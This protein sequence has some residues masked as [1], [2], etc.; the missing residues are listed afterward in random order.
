MN[1][2]PFLMR[3]YVL[4]ALVATLLLSACNKPLEAPEAVIEKAKQAVIDV[5]SGQ[6]EVV[7]TVDG[8]NGR[9]D[10]DFDGNMSLT[11]DKREEDNSKFDLHLDVSGKMQTGEQNLDGDLDVNFITMDKE[12]YVMLNE[13]SSSDPSVASIEPFINLYS[14]KW[15][16]IAEDFIP[17][18]IRE[19]QGQDEAF[20]LKKKQLEDLFA[21]TTLFDVVK[22]Y[23]VEKL[24]GHSVHHYGLAVNMNG[25]KDY[26][27]KAAIIDG[28][29]LT[30][31]E[32][33][34][35]VTVLSY[36]REAEVYID[37]DTYHIIKSVFRFSGEA[38]SSDA[39]LEVEIV[40]DGSDYNKSVSIEV[41][42]D[43][44]DFNPLNLIMGL[45]GVPALPEEDS[46][47]LEEAVSEAMEEHGSVMMEEVT[48]E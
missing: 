27:S 4:L 19:L 22:E 38:I 12:Y 20:M 15:L 26:M 16:R 13:L 21:E 48:E 37:V 31:Q 33:E 28:R 34:E 17:E 7:A 11:F 32:I 9:D 40:V 44:E 24:N 10:L 30:Q 43:A 18:N 23:G 8:N 29:E 5:Q 3:K 6:V 14:G 45:G 39:S 35:A 36:I 41:P 42:E 47:M 1:K 2:Q 25:F 46:A